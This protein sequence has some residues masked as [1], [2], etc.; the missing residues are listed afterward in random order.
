MALELSKMR[1]RVG[2]WGETKRI[3][4]EGNEVPKGELGDYK[5]PTDNHSQWVRMRQDKLRALMRALHFS[6]QAAVVQK[7]DVSADSEARL[8]IAFATKL[9]KLASLTTTEKAA[10]WEQLAKVEESY[11]ELVEYDRESPEYIFA[12]QEL[13]DE[14]SETS[15]YF[16]CLINHDKL[17]VDYEDKVISIPFEENTVTIDPVKDNKDI[18]ETGFHNGTVFKWVHGNKEEWTP[19]TYWIVYMQYSEE[20]AYFRGEIRKADQEIEIIVIDDD[21]NANTLVYRGWMTGPNETNTLWNTKHGISWNDLNYTKQ[22]FITKDENT[23]VFFERFDRVI[24]NGQPWEIQAY[25]ENYGTNSSNPNTG[26]IRV[27]LKETYTTTEEVLKERAAEEAA[28]AEAGTPAIIGAEV[29]APYDTAVYSVENLGEGSWT[30][31][32]VEG[33]SKTINELVSYSV[34]SNNVLHLEIIIGKSF[35]TGFNIKYGDFVKHVTIKSL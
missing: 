4:S 22:L 1:R 15:P 29:L 14:Q 9:E 11:P 2:Y 13:A 32:A 24:I 35:K 17:K 8:L 20:T 19:D 18:V 7:Y 34:D 3:D 21:G 30:V 10:L 27:A 12:L 16:R 5:K 25:N 31:E 28:R 26:I 33:S 6:Y 23:A